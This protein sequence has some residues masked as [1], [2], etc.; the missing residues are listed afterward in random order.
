M[1]RLVS[2]RVPLGGV[3]EAT[4]DAQ[5]QEQSK[6]AFTPSLSDLGLPS[7]LDQKQSDQ[8]PSAR[9]SSFCLHLSLCLS[10]GSCF[11]LFFHE[12]W[13]HSVLTS[14]LYGPFTS[15]SCHNMSGFLQSFLINLK[16]EKTIH[17]LLFPQHLVH[18]SEVL[19]T[20]GNFSHALDEETEISFKGQI[21]GDRSASRASRNHE[22]LQQGRD[23]PE[24]P[25]SCPHALSHRHKHWPRC[26]TQGL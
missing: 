10:L 17:V 2:Q 12:F 24:W 13:L 11:V 9:P 8:H 18:T 23:K 3:Y 4:T 14:S 21:C 22:R 15:C 16:N 26:D 25:V 5:R 19:F 1:L 7:S 6:E 20:E